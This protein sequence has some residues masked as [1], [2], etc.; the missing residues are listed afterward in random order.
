MSLKNKI[1]K[2]I[3]G[4]AK[5]AGSAVKTKAKSVGQSV[6]HKGDQAKSAAKGT[7]RSAKNAGSDAASSAKSLKNKASN[8]VHAKRN[9]RR[10]LDKNAADWVA[11]FNR[12]MNWTSLVPPDA[13]N[14]PTP[15][16][17]RQ[18]QLAHLQSQIADSQAKIHTAESDLTTLMAKLKTLSPGDANY[19]K[20]ED[21]IEERGDALADAKAALQSGLLDKQA[22]LQQKI[23]QLASGDAKLAGVLSA[24][25]TQVNAIQIDGTAKLSDDYR[26]RLDAFRKS[27]VTVTDMVKRAGDETFA[28][29]V[30][31]DGVSE[32]T[33]VQV[34][35]KTRLYILT[36]MLDLA[37][38]QFQSAAGKDGATPGS[39][40]N[41]SAEN[42]GQSATNST[43]VHYGPYRIHNGQRSR[44]V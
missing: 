3:S 19:N 20:L 17:E 11:R 24:L 6:A 23:D 16:T 32:I 41:R 26:R 22:L 15:Q 14:E 25:E 42:T 31:T 10:A 34:L 33:Q 35:D 36:G 30:G 21:L 43:E 44:L 38:H 27:H 13:A 7:L 18:K 2:K 12:E 37:M 28:M 40:R 8:V 4:A 1:S 39:G 29:E 5:D 9:K